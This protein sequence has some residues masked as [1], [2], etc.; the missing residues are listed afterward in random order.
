MKPGEITRRVETIARV[1]HD[2]EAAHVRED[3]LHL[4]FIKYVSRDESVPI[5][6]RRKAK[7]V[8]EVATWD[9]QRVCS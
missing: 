9:F 4:D 2:A 6:V 5:A 8:L 1:M 3:E 7:Q